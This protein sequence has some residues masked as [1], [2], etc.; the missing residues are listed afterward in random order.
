MV[1]ERVFF[2]VKT[3]AKKMNETELIVTAKIVKLLPE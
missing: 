3:G 2:Q 1:T